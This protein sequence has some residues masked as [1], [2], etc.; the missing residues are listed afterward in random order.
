MS[1]LNHVAFI[2]DGNRRFARKLMKEPWKGHELGYGK[3]KEVVSWLKD[4]QVKE[5]TF[6]AFSSENFNRPK[7]EFNYLMKLFE[8]GARELQDEPAVHENKICIRFIGEIDRFPQAVQEQV[9]KAMEMTKNYSNYRINIALGYGGRQEILH[10]VKAIV[11]RAVSGDLDVASISAD[12][13]E[14]S[15]YLRSE[16]QLIIRTGGERRTSNFLVW[17]SSYSEWYF[18]DKAW[19]EFT[20]DDFDI[21]VQDYKNRNRRFGK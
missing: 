5:A 12:T 18:C 20:R 9:N 19:P 13:V 14:Q 1:T 17:Q 7:T 2:M 15:L 11:S 8:K 10:A 16:P 3:L 21:A 4:A 6:Y